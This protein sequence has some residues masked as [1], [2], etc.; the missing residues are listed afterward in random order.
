MESFSLLE[1]FS[2]LESFLCLS[3]FSVGDLP[4]FSIG[5]LDLPDLSLGFLSFNF[6]FFLAPLLDRD[7]E[8]VK[9]RFPL[10]LAPLPRD[11]DRTFLLILSAIVF[12][13]DPKSLESLA[14]GPFFFLE[15]TFLVFFLDLDLDFLPDLDRFLDLDLELLDELLDDEDE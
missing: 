2:F 6:F 9:E 4:P 5:D 14:V 11:L 1:S 13:F 3:T 15:L 7:R 8:G 10:I 12:F